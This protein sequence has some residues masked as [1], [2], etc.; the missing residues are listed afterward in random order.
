MLLFSGRQITDATLINEAL[1][2]SSRVLPYFNPKANG[3]ERDGFWGSRCSSTIKG[4]A[5]GIPYH[6]S[7]LFAIEGLSRCREGLNNFNGGFGLGNG[8]GPPPHLSHLLFADDTL[9]HPYDLKHCRL[10]IN[11]SKSTI[12]PC[13]MRSPIRRYAA[14]HVLR[15]RSFPHHHLL[16][17]PWFELRLASPQ[18]QY[19]SGRLTLIN[20]VLTRFP[21]ILC[22]YPLCQ[23]GYNQEAAACKEV[24]QA[25]Y[26]SDS[27]WCSNKVTLMALGPR[28]IRNR[29]KN[30]S[31]MPHLRWEMGTYSLERY[32]ARDTPL[33]NIFP[34]IFQIRSHPHSTISADN[35]YGH[36]SLVQ[37][38]TT[39]QTYSEKQDGSYT[40]KHAT[41]QQSSK[42]TSTDATC[43]CSNSNLLITCS[44]I[45]Q[46]ATGLWNMFF[47]LF[48]SLGSCQDHERG[49]CVGVLGKLGSP[50]LLVG[51]VPACILWCLWTERNK[52]CF[53]G[54]PTPIS[55]FK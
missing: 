47:S 14:Y 49:F 27:Y 25:K 10:H 55:T 48:D 40:L 28:D 9:P 41:F 20:S 53:D 35:P 22:P 5:C 1:D 50:P 43:A 38:T 34:S 7:F 21:P 23:I 24:I 3:F 31:S 11:M 45:A 15:H 52:R 46:L 32:L 12:Y 18:Q 44:F 37:S 33:M 8:Y 19:L 29:G 54:T 6:P 16:G 30:S 26:G 2:K 39:G 17:M 51:L 4:I 42:K 13:E 36:H